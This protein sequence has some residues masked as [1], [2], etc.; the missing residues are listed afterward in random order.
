MNGVFRVWVCLRCDFGS[1][2]FMG[3]CF[4]Y[5]WVVLGLE[6]FFKVRTVK[7]LNVFRAWIISG[8]W[9]CIGWDVL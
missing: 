6:L 2:F 7:D 4:L 8:F 1:A 9:F 3:S 5:V